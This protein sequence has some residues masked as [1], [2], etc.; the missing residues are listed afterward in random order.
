MKYDVV[1]IGSGLGALECA[2]IL[3]EEGKKVVLLEREVQPGGCLQSYNRKGLSFD[4]GLHYVGG[5]AEGQALYKP[6][7]MLGLLNLPW[8]RLD[9]DGFDR[10]TIGERTYRYAEG[11]QAFVEQLA[12]D[13]PEEREG[14]QKY[15]EMLQ[16]SD[17]DQFEGLFGSHADMVNS[18]VGSPMF[19][20]GAWDYLHEII[21]NEL[22][23]NILSGSS[24]KLELRKETLPLFTFAHCNGS[25]I[26]SSWRLKGDGNLIVD[27]LLRDIKANGGEIFCKAEVEQL[28]EKD[29]KIVTAIC[30]DGRCFEGDLFVSDVHPAVTFDMIQESQYIKKIFRRRICRMENTFGMFTA[31]IVLQPESVEYFNYNQFVYDQPDVWDFYQKKGPVRGVMIS[32]RVPEN[33]EKY[34]RQI[35]LL[36]PM[37][38]SQCEEWADSKVGRR[39]EGYQ[40]LMTQKIKECIALA[41][42]VIPGLSGKISEVYTSSPLTYRDYTL[43]SQGSA[44]GLRKDYNN[45]MLTT[46]SPRTPVPNLLLTGQSL[47]VHG[48]HGV[49]MTALMTCAEILGKETIYKKLNQ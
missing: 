19:T 38:W 3:S 16:H 14:L 34:A 37:L 4:T 12:S 13:F 25:Y 1:I 15:V 8:K 49:T 33:G 42:R 35:D 44:Y 17:R 32:C 22:L 29:G 47:M 5:L 9:A 43:T 31:S 21:H 39:G 24:L 23:I 11:Y 46:L 7:K 41:E 48:I 40:Q 20:T 6:F 18:P 2:H 27:A 28:V 30:K 26:A 36:T 10:I 45:P